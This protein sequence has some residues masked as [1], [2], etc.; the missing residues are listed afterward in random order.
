M[1]GVHRRGSATCSRSQQTLSHVG[2]KRIGT[3]GRERLGTCWRVTCVFSPQQ[4]CAGLTGL[5]S[6]RWAALHP[7]PP[8]VEGALRG[9][10]GC[11][12]PGLQNSPGV[13]PALLP[14]ALPGLPPRRGRFPPR[15]APGS[16]GAARANACA[17]AQPWAQP[18]TVGH[19]AGSYQLV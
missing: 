9:G 2:H 1:E 7:A 4:A 15:P 3:L 8:R 11:P 6:P 14:P 19:A 5:L 12:N 10:K 16:R 18:W 17:A 13:S